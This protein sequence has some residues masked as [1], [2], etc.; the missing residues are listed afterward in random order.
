LVAFEK[1]LSKFIRQGSKDFASFCDNILCEKGFSV[2]P[3]MKMKYQLQLI[4]GK[5]LQVAIS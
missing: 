3:V 2:I 5:E 1:L 4:I